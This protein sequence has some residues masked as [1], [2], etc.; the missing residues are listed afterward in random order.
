M[1]RCSE[2][3]LLTHFHK[4]HAL[5]NIVAAKKFGPLKNTTPD[6]SAQKERLQG[7]HWLYSVSRKATRMGIPL[8]DLV[9]LST[10]LLAIHERAFLHIVAE[11][12][13]QRVEIHPCCFWF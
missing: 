11:P 6:P 3:I 8:N 10:S 4:E 9:S 13:G 12:Y 1:Q 7:D 5:T 2:R